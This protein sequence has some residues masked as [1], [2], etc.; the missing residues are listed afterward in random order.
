MYHSLLLFLLPQHPPENA[1]GGGEGGEGQGGGG[2][3]KGG[4]GGPGQL[5]CLG[6]GHLHHRQGGQ[7][8]HTALLLQELN[9]GSGYALL[10]G[11]LGGGR[12]TSYWSD[13]QAGKLKAQTDM[14][15]SK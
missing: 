10:H 3:E 7:T 9:E 12:L 8:P 6:P 14:A 5:V 15:T 11:G 13:S 4:G 2:G 1:R